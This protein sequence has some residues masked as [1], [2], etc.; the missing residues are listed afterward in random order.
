VHDHAAAVPC[1]YRHAATSIRTKVTSREE[2]RAFAD[3]GPRP[4]EDTASVDEVQQAQLR[5]QAITPPLSRDEVILLLD[6]FGHDN[7]FESIQGGV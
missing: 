6:S 4:A 1:A 3:L 7:C 5:L 2:V